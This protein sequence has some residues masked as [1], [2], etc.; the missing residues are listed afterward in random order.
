MDGCNIA[1]IIQ[2]YAAGDRI[3]EQPTQRPDIQLFGHRVLAVLLLL[4][5]LSDLAMPFMLARIPDIELS[6]ISIAFYVLIG[7]L[8]I[9]GAVGF[10]LR[11]RWGLWLVIAALVAGAL[12]AVIQ[13]VVL[14]TTTGQVTGLL[15]VMVGLL[16]QGAII[17]H[18]Y[19]QRQSFD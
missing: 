14:Q 9:G 12:N 13:V 19:Q 7:L 16:V 8:A 6:T 2:L 5:G 1:L 18:F 15:G 10:W 11:R 4:Y 17:Y 3:V